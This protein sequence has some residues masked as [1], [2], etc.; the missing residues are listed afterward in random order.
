MT[1]KLKAQA[2][3]LITYIDEVLFADWWKQHEEE[4]QEMAEDTDPSHYDWDELAPFDA[5]DLRNG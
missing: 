2:I 5:E 3:Q 4:L 1:S